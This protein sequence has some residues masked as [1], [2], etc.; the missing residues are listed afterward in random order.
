M[1]TKPQG[2]VFTDPVAYRKAA[3]KWD[4]DNYFDHD[5][6]MPAGHVSEP[7]PELKSSPERLYTGSALPS[8]S[9][10]KAQRQAELD[11]HQ[12]AIDAGY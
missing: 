9:E 10:V 1:S 5:N 2:E 3:D 12:A 6:Q 11:A 4:R 8:P 7:R